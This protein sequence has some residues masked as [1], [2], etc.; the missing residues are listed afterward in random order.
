MIT[1]NAVH[2]PLIHERDHGPDPLAPNGPL[3]WWRAPSPA[4]VAE[5]LGNRDDE[6]VLTTLV[7]RVRPL[8]VELA[9]VVRDRDPAELTAATIGPRTTEGK[10]FSLADDL[11]ASAI[12]LEAARG[13]AT[14][15]VVVDHLRRRAGLGA[16]AWSRAARPRKE[17]AAPKPPCGVGP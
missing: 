14:S 1:K 12:L 5:R 2:A 17:L 15:R 9:R 16:L 13:D 6:A 3:A 8:A 11:L 7:C 4:M 10:G